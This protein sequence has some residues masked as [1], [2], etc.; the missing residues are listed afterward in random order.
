V[1]QIMRVIPHNDLPP[2]MSRKAGK[3]KRE[4]VVIHDSDSDED[5]RAGGS[6]GPGQVKMVQRIGYLE[7]SLNRFGGIRAGF[8]TC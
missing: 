4:V 6:S 2:A 5:G 1:L 8:G 3:R 7:V